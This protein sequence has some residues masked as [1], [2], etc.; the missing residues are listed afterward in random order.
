MEVQGKLDE[1]SRRLNTEGNHCEAKATEL[2]QVELR[3]EELL[4][5]LQLL[6][7]Q[8]KDLSSQVV[9]S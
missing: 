1:A 6:E 8:K 2:K 7:D 4:K 5:E 9:A 3:R